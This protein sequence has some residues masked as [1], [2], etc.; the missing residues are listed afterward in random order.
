VHADADRRDAGGQEGA[1]RLP[2]RV[3]ES[4][5]SWRELLIDIRRGGLIEAAAKT[6]R[7]LKD[8]NQ[9]PKIVA[10]VRLADGIAVVPT[11]KS[12]AA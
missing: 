9:L 6:C 11:K 3:R 4:P 10:G 7:R 8:T 12:H 5:Q 1:D 2:G